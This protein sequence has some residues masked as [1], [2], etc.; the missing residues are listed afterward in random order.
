MQLTNANGLVQSGLQFSVYY[1]INKILSMQ[2][3]VA[4]H[5]LYNVQVVF[6]FFERDA[7][8]YM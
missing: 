5:E 7:A 1:H 4:L 8:L 2:N 6:R 3:A